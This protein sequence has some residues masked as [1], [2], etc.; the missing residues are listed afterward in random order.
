MSSGSPGRGFGRP[1]WPPPVI[2][3]VVTPRD[4]ALCLQTPR[5]NITSITDPVL[6]ILISAH[7]ADA[8]L[9]AAGTAEQPLQVEF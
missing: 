5:K 1:G 8:S 3:I 2:I 7:I 9:L 4:A 6:R